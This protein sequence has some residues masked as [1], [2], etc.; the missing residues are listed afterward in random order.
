[1]STLAVAPLLDTFSAAAQANVETVETLF[2]LL[3]DEEL[4]WKPDAQRW[5]VAECIQHLNLTNRHYVGEMHRVLGKSGAHAPTANYKPGYFG[6]KLYTRMHP[7]QINKKVKTFGKLNPE[8]ARLDARTVLNEYLD[9]G[10]EVVALIE[11]S[12]SVDIGK[13]RINSAIG[14]LLR[15]KLGDAIQIVVNHDMRHLLQAQRVLELQTQMPK[16]GV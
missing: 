10:R 9:R 3:S 14:P 8:N 16:S 2:V 12:R 7:D 4:L 13:I 15:F 1:M 5:S 6:R 11:K